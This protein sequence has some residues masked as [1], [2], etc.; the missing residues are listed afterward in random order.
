MDN[1]LIAAVLSVACL[2]F[3][4]CNIGPKPQ[5]NEE[6]ETKMTED[7][8]NNQLVTVEYLKEAYEIADGDIPDEYLEAFIDKFGITYKAM[9][10]T[11]YK[12]HLEKYYAEGSGVGYSIMNKI[13]GPETDEPLSS[14]ASKSDYIF[15][16][17]EV[18]SGEAY[19]FSGMVI[20]FKHN[21]I[22][23]GS[24]MNNYNTSQCSC[25]LKAEDKE[26]IC[27]EII[28]HIHDDEYKENHTAGTKYYFKIWFID[29]EKNH[30]MF[31]GE[32]GD[33]FNY[34]GLEEYITEVLFKQYLKTEFK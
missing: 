23:Y 28:S 34:P 29:G 31:S 7:D 14:F 21:M 4:A 33:E 30:R 5:I 11:S 18:P 3:V 24:D 27:T 25:E 16:Q 8:I 26:T 9:E 6:V 19:I 13:N 1:R 32:A 2:G 15:I 22:Y 20:D 10:E 12:Y 17:F